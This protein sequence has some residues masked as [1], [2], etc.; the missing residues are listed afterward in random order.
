MKK[1]KHLMITSLLVL[2][3]CLVGL[4]L[5][6]QLPDQMPT[7]FGVNGADGW[8][9]K[10][11]AV[12][13]IPVMMLVFHVIIYAATLLDKQNQQSGN[14]KVLDII[15]YIFPVISM[16]TSGIVYAISLGQ[17]ANVSLLMIKLMPMLTGLMFVVMGNYMPKCRMNSTL[18][19]K[20]KWT[21]HNEENW[22]KTHR[23][24]GITFVLGGILMMIF[25]LLN[26]FWAF[27]PVMFALILIPMVY[28]WQLY[29]KQIASGAYQPGNPRI[30]V[31]AKMG[32]ASKIIVAVIVILVALLL[33]SGN[34]ESEI[35][36]SLL[37]ISA[38]YAQDITVDLGH[39]TVEF[40]EEGISGSRVWG[41]G[42]ARLALGSFQN[43]SLGLH[44]RYTYTQ[45]KPCILLTVDGQYLVLN[46]KTPEATRALYEQIIDLQSAVE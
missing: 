5:W 46:A 12:F 44:T 25:G 21:F 40:V 16:V 4:A 42:S 38:T 18:G 32:R 6:D 31:S 1:Y 30:S 26:W 35:E 9:S 22:N 15:L 39:A 33:C 23:V 36:G 28:S 27:V 37:H 2:L 14:R 8:S 13:G 29:K 19:I 43:D 20:T 3:P 17:N 11:F 7:H 34:V 10:G 45:C 24:G 41:F